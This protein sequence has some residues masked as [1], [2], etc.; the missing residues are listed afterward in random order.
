MALLYIG[1]GRSVFL[2]EQQESE[3]HRHKTLEIL[4]ALDHSFAYTTDSRDWQ[5]SSAIAIN[6]DVAHAFRDFRGMCVSIH[7][8]PEKRWMTHLA[9][10]FFRNEPVRRLD[11]MDLSAYTEF[12]RSL[13]VHDTGASVVFRMCELLIEEIAGVKGYRGVVDERLLR[14]LERIE[15]DLPDHHS[16]E[17]LARDVCLSEDRFLHLFSEQLGVPLRHH[18][19]HQRVIRATRD[20]LTGTP[21]TEAAIAAGFSDS[22]HFTHTCMQ[23]TGL[24]PSSFKRYRGHA[25]IYFCTSSRC[26]RPTTD[27][28]EGLH[29]NHCG[30]Y[31]VL[32]PSMKT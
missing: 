17:E 9:T 5:T 4:F 2:A 30:L 21:L 13:L 28:P 25:Q 8:L 7:L 10:D 32:R 18:I 23:L 1:I 6:S 26:V 15:K 19:M 11:Q 20:I 16:S 27:D 14:V 24:R 12:F 3:M 31:Q 22:S 29:C